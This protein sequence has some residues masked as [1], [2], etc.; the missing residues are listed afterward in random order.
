MPKRGSEEARFRIANTHNRMRNIC[1]LYEHIGIIGRYSKNTSLTGRDSPSLHFLPA[2]VAVLL[3]RFHASV[4]NVEAHMVEEVVE[5]PDIHWQAFLFTAK[6]RRLKSSALSK[7]FQNHFPD[8]PGITMGLQNLR[9]ILP[10]IWEEFGI[11]EESFIQGQTGSAVA[12]QMG[13]SQDVH[14]RLYARIQDG[15]PELTSKLCRQMLKFSKA[16]HN[17]WG[18]GNTVPDINVAKTNI[19][20]DIAGSSAMQP[21]PMQI[22]SL[23][24]SITRL[25][26]Q[27]ATSNEAVSKSM[28]KIDLLYSKILPAMESILTVLPSL[29]GPTLLKEDQ[30]Q[31]PLLSNDSNPSVSGN[32]SPSPS[33]IPILRVLPSNCPPE[34]QLRSPSANHSLTPVS[35]TRND[36]LAE[37][38]DC[39]PEP[40]NLPVNS[41]SSLVVQTLLEG[42]P[43][44]PP[45]PNFPLRHL[46]SEAPRPTSSPSHSP[47]HLFSSPGSPIQISL[48]VSPSPASRALGS[49]RLSSSQQQAFWHPSQ[50]SHLF[51][52]V[53]PQHDMDDPKVPRTKMPVRENSNPTTI[54]V[55]LV[56]LL[57]RQLAP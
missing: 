45:L 52:S 31:L 39:L 56:I 26:N 35:S 40:S 16:L 50:P 36:L 29:S 7:A 34:L 1:F 18:F 43:L 42:L 57:H 24:S 2:A 25:E 9:H 3:R 46:V 55:R 49:V 10:A 8:Y 53:T 37:W 33:M 28:A 6:G 14:N 47:S 48:T 30:V 27:I 21:L 22:I 12:Y 54:S 44:T 4:A 17:F 32:P 38:P 19:L 5:E 15:H 51:P 20:A 11:S 13:H 41:P 23:R